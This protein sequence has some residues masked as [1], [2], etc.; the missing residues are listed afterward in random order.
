MNYFE[1]FDLPIALKVDNQGLSKKYFELQK[2]FHP[3]YYGN[4][5]DAEKD[6]ALEMSS[7]INK[8][9]KTFQSPDETIKYVLQLKGLLEEEEKYVL[10]PGF[11]MEVLELNEMK[12]D[13]ATPE[14]INTR[15]NALQEEIYA[16]AA[17]II[18]N[19]REGIT[20][21]DELQSVKK[22]YY[23]KKYLDRLLK[24]D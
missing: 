2:K 19:Y 8:A 16:E 15:A 9:F 7:Q 5:S 1:L 12:M 18:N 10:P 17:S 3:D 6:A 23:K 13:G 14:E 22:Y 4:E 20:T 11:L 24:P 21:N